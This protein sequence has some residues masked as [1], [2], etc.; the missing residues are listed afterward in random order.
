MQSTSGFNFGK[1]VAMMQ[2][3]RRYSWQDVEMQS[4]EF[5]SERRNVIP[6][7][8]QDRAER[9]RKLIEVSG[10]LGYLMFWESSFVVQCYMTDNLRQQ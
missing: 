4:G 2:R 10:S 8:P 9:H 3:I 1:S 5:L 6:M 7:E